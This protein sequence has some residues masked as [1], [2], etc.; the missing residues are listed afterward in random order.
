[1]ISLNKAY[2]TDSM[3]EKIIYWQEEDCCGLEEDIRAIDDAITF[4]ACGH[5]YPEM[6]SEKESM[7]VIAA[8]GFLKRRLRLF[9]GK[10]K[11]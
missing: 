5:E 10:E 7:A 4:M 9:N 6:L 11:R 3:I 2:I 1:M 8:L